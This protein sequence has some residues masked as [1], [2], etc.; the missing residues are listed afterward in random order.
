MKK[1]R[2]GKTDLKVSRVGMGGIPLQRPSEKEAVELVEYALDKGINIIDT[3]RAYGDSEKRIG[4]GI[5]GRRKEVCVISRTPLV[6]KKGAL[7]YLDESLKNLKTDYLD[8]WQFHNISTMER[9][10]KVIGDNGALEAAKEAQLLGKINHIGITGHNLEVIE[11]A[12]KSELFEVILFPFNFVNNE[13]A[14]NLVSLTKELDIGFTAMKPFAGGRLRDAKLAIK[15]LLQFD[16]V[17]PVPGVEKK[18]EIDEL[19]EIATSSWKITKTEEQRM[20][21]IRRELGLPFCQ[22]CGYCMQTC[23]QEINIPGVINIHL[24]WELWPQETFA[25]RKRKSVDVAR[26][27]I[28]CGICEEKCPYHLPIREMLVKGIEFYDNKSKSTKI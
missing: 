13:A 17:V 2:L 15:Y 9:Y 26:T 5:E 20:D 7:K 28:K 27:C 11:K 19:V 18:E 12:V 21:K 16:N 4:K 10:Q 23:P 25:Q 6:D 24:N 1:V 22:W 3:A 8:I 14:E